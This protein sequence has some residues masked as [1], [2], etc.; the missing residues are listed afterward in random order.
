MKDK[1]RNVY[2]AWAERNHKLEIPSNEKRKR[3]KVNGM[4]LVNAVSGEIYLQ[5][6]EKSKTENV[7]AYLANLA[8]D[9]HLGQTGKRSIVLDNNSTHKQKMTSFLTKK[10]DNRELG[11]SK[12]ITLEFMYT[13]A[14]SPDF[15]LAEY[16]VYL[17]RLRELHNLPSDTIIPKITNNLKDIN[18]LMNPSQ[19]LLSISIH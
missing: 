15:D 16:G 4:L 9:V 12:K 11:L 2:C 1:E 14:C 10:I 3:H 18:I 7:V 13:P 19:I 17:L 6:K 5:L 8:S